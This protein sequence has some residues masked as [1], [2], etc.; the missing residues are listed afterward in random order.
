M[1]QFI[2]KYYLGTKRKNNPNYWTII[3]LFKTTTKV[4]ALKFTNHII[5]F[6]F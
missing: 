5:E 4:I 2:S 6:I 1:P 3:Y